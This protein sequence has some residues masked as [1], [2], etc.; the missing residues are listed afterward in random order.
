MYIRIHCYSG[1]MSGGFFQDINKTDMWTTAPGEYNGYLVSE[2][3]DLALNRYMDGQSITCR[4]YKLDKLL[5]S[6]EDTVTLDID[7]KYP[8][9]HVETMIQ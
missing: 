5:E 8:D 3:I 7:C 2:N 4:S 1:E 6:V 9:S